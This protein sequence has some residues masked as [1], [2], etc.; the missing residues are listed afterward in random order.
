MKPA[1]SAIVGFDGGGEDPAV[2]PDDVVIEDQGLGVG[3]QRC[4]PYIFGGDI[5]ALRDAVYHMVW[6][7]AVEVLVKKASGGAPYGVEERDWLELQPV[8]HSD[9]K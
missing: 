7:E 4:S 6:R 8:G 2:S 3:A 9:E 5:D 1:P